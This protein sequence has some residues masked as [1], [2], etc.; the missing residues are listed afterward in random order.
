LRNVVGKLPTTT[1]WQPMLPRTN[2]RDKKLCAQFP[3]LAKMTGCFRR[4]SG[5][6]S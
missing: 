6:Q 2:N 5:P 4:R 3:I 1:G